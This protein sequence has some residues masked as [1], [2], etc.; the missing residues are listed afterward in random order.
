MVTDQSC[1]SRSALLLTVFRP[2]NGDRLADAARET[3]NETSKLPSAQCWLLAHAIRDRPAPP[4]NHR[5]AA[6][7]HGRRCGR[8]QPHKHPAAATEVSD[9]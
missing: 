1:D 6:P 9:D 2:A 4:A 3:S 8:D 7:A 5:D